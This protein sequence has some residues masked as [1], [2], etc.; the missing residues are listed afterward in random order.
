[1]VLHLTGVHLVLGVVSRVLV[2]VRHEDSL[3]IRRFH[4]L[5]GAAISVSACTDFVVERAI[6]LV[7]LSSENGC[8]IVGHG[9]LLSRL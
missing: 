9:E 5:S 7:L 1:M 3:R 4:M 2:H 6:D 8:K